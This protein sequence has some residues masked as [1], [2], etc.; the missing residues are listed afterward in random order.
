MTP[1]PSNRSKKWIP[2]IAGVVTR[3]WLV[4]A[5]VVYAGA[6]LVDA[7]FRYW[8]TL[9]TET[10]ILFRETE[11]AVSIQYPNKLTVDGPRHQGR[12]TIRLYD[13]VTDAS[14]S[15]PHE[16]ALGP[17][18]LPIPTL[19]PTY[20]PTVS[21]H[22]NPPGSA[23]A[24][25]IYIVYASQG[26]NL[27]SSD[28]VSQLP[29]SVTLSADIREASLL[30]EHANLQTPPLQ[31]F[32]IIGEITIRHNSSGQ[33]QTARISLEQPWV[34]F[35][36]KWLGAGASVAAVFALI[37]L[38][39]DELRRQEKE[40]RSL[41]KDQQTEIGRF[42]KIVAQV[43]D[44]RSLR[45]S[46]GAL[47]QDY[48]PSDNLPEEVRRQFEDRRQATRIWEKYPGNV[49]IFREFSEPFWAGVYFNIV[50]ISAEDRRNQIVEQIQ[51]MCK[52]EEEYVEFMKGL[53]DC[54]S[55]EEVHKL[56][57][58]RSLLRDVAKWYVENSCPFDTLQGF[59]DMTNRIINSLARES[60]GQQSSNITALASW[61]RK[62][63]VE[64]LRYQFGRKRMRYGDRPLWPLEPTSKK[65]Q[66]DANY[67][68]PMQ[69]QHGTGELTTDYAADD[70]LEPDPGIESLCP[71][72]DNYMHCYVL[73]PRGA[74]KTWLRIYFDRI[75]DYDSRA[76]LIFFF[77]PVELLYD[78]SSEG[79]LRHLAS[80][81]ANHLSAVLIEQMSLMSQNEE[82][83]DYLKKM[84]Q[85]VPFLCRYGYQA[86][87]GI[88][89][90]NEPTPS[91]DQVDVEQAYRQNHLSSRLAELQKMMSECRVPSLIASG[92]HHAQTILRDMKMAVE[93]ANFDH[94][95]VLIDNLERANEDFRDEF[96]DVLSQPDFLWNLAVHGIYLKV[97]T[98][99]DH[100]VTHLRENALSASQLTET[101]H[102]NPKTDKSLHLIC[103][104]PAQS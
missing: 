27:I 103:Y 73:G 95:Y 104:D 100:L 89:S 91:S 8:D 93:A 23:D 20:T 22:G 24:P 64:R 97:F 37:L 55:N 17:D 79:I 48:T 5:V 80:N 96:W 11:Y 53:H 16:D 44:V 88:D 49:E 82:E 63:Q 10:K 61:A 43:Q 51:T 65:Y 46:M 41:T 30:I 1:T 21:R 56:L 38:A 52:Q 58:G 4:L 68:F 31:T 2:R 83:E 77:L 81:I 32:P 36:R 99:D 92:E 70:G 78:H 18:S 26:I 28:S 50:W 12:L 101:Q 90:L 67:D 59:Y 98:E 75:Y 62:Q 15:N 40:Q 6:A 72:L 47:Q 39:V 19:I 33:P 66:G 87:T 25:E 74:G 34:E 71:R 35:L 57:G 86:A 14:E 54:D 60:F 45:E 69:E 94:L 9:R 85:V 3:R 102:R 42:R 7:G 76:L 84:R 29:I 13:N